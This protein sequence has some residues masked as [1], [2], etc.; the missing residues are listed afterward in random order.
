MSTV[1]S[2]FKFSFLDCFFNVFIDLIVPEC[3]KTPEEM[4]RG[5][6]A[7]KDKH[8]PTKQYVISNT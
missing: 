2:Y 8:L 1:C 3:G 5:R 6:T 7:A 4:R